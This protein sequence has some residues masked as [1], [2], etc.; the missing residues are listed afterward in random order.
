M[1]PH[2][3]YELHTTAG[4]PSA[5]GW[6]AVAGHAVQ[7]CT[8]WPMHRAPSI[9]CTAC[10]CEAHPVRGGLLVTARPPPSGGRR[11]VAGH[12]VQHSAGRYPV[13]L[14]Q[15]ASRRHQPQVPRCWP[16]LALP[17]LHRQT[18]CSLCAPCQCGLQT[19]RQVP[20]QPSGRLL[21]SGHSH[22][23]EASTPVQFLGDTAQLKLNNLWHVRQHSFNW[24][25]DSF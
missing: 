11:A 17:Y 2:P 4:P 9:L 6:R 8:C 10:S 19:V 16:P 15:L 18:H 3:V 14:P 1:S 12:A 7:P 20:R 21:T 25:G 24:K 5:G 23:L 13:V 22:L